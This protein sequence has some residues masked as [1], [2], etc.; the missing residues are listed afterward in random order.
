MV[1]RGKASEA[2]DSMILMIWVNSDL[3]HFIGGT[4]WINGLNERI[5]G[6]T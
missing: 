1:E 3:Y 5:V 4:R 6:P 2:E